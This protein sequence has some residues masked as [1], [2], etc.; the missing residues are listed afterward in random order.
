MAVIPY[1][2]IA[3]LKNASDFKRYIDKLNLP[4]PFD[5]KMESGANATL[6]QPIE[7]QGRTIGN[8]LCV[9]PMEGW[10]GTTD[11]LPT[12][13]TKRRWRHFGI[14]GCKLIWGG[15]AFA[16]CHEGKG[17]PN[18]LMINEQTIGEIADLRKTLV[19]GH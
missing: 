8:R 13:L 18:Q 19:R 14:S 10:D 15:E 3:S 4:I 2:K 16:V 9:L 7:F 11:G 1:K 5:D 17:N 6:N 12:E